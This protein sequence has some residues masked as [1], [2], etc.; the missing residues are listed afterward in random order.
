MMKKT[1][2]VVALLAIVSTSSYGIVVDNG[3]AG[4][5][6]TG[7]WLAS[8]GGNYYGTRSEYSKEADAT[9]TFRTAVSGPRDVYLW[10]TYY[11]NR[12]TSVPVE[13]YDGNSLL[14][15]VFVD[16][17]S[18]AGQWNMLGTY[19]F[20]GTA[21]IVIISEGDCTTNADAVRLLQ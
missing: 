16:Q 10:F 12:C 3:G 20:S 1:L 7:T 19:D 2:F 13:I 5:S 18:D 21:R 17:L 9:Y 14:D 6:S 15:T 11:H 4:T 8:Y